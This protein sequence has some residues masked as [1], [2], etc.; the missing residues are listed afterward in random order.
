MIS[1]HYDCILECKIFSLYGWCVFSHRKNIKHRKRA[2]I[3]PHTIFAEPIQSYIKFY[4]PNG[5]KTS[6]TLK[7]KPLEMNNSG[8]YYFSCISHIVYIYVYNTCTHHQR[9]CFHYCYFTYTH[10]QAY[11]YIYIY[12]CNC[13]IIL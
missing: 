5:V 13:R 8:K 2:C 9:I 1:Y 11:I 4:Y 3:H 12:I 7:Q 6:E 10:K